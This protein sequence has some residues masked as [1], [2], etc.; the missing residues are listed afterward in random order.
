MLELCNVSK[1]FP[2]ILAVDK[3]SFQANA[4]EITG[5][6]GPNGSCAR[7]ALLAKDNCGIIVGGLVTLSD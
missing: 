1:R 7:R 6:L 3:V 4:G 5:Y 2:A